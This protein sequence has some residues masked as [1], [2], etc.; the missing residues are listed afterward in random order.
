MRCSFV[1][2]ATDSSKGRTGDEGSDSGLTAT[3]E[4]DDAD[5]VF[6]RNSARGGTGFCVRHGKLGQCVAMMCLKDKAN[7]TD[8]PN[9][10]CAKHEKMT[11][12]FGALGIL[13]DATTTVV[14][15]NRTTHAE[16]ASSSCSSFSSSP[17]NVDAL[18]SS[19]SYF[20]RGASSPSL[21]LYLRLLRLLRLRLSLQV[22][23][24]RRC[25]MLF[26]HTVLLLSSHKQNLV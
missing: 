22:G 4:A 1:S 12:R 8:E 23:P 19:F 13:G 5:V 3:D 6:C 17:T 2:R 10:F 7:K 25:Q 16:S 18:T 9:K 20:P 15:K 14:H 24:L 26:T 11:E 21:G